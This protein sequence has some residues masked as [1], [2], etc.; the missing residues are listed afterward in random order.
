M[1]DLFIIFIS[2]FM[3]LKSFFSGA[4]VRSI[5]YAAYIITGLN[6]KVNNGQILE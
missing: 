6:I 2:I 5:L 3:V 1:E 4:L